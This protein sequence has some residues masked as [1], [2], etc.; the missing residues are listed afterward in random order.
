[1][2]VDLIP[3]KVCSFNCIYC[4]CGPT[5]KLTLDRD[6][7]VPAQQVKQE[8]QHYLSQHPAPDYITFSGAGEPTLHAKFGAILNFIKTHWP[9]IPVAV[10]TNGS[11]LGNPQVRQELLGAD[12]VMPS[13]DAAL[14]PSFRR[15]DRPAR[16]IAIADIIE[17]L[18]AFR[19][20]YRGS[21]LLEVFILPGYNDSE[22]DLI[23]LKKA[24]LK[25]KPDQ[26]Q[27]NSLDRPGTIKGLVAA[28]PE[29][30]QEIV[31]FWQLDYVEIIAAAPERK[32]T[33]AYRKDVE[34]AI[35]ET[36]KR[37]PCTV[38]DIAKILGTH[39]N[40]INKYLGPL[41]SEDKIKAV[42]QARGLFYQIKGENGS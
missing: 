9:A 39:I 40:E 26:V 24:L 2:G 5:T 29:R 15:I 19:K 12:L 35:L 7:Y 8:L 25:I 41:E 14:E 3:H 6:E 42:R 1:M 21:L 23:A 32:Q 36:I 17:G 27:L 28:S 30:L 37:R 31:D 11:L 10:L 16:N 38:D 4:E 34:S 22:P 13:L 33:E 20:E 18:I